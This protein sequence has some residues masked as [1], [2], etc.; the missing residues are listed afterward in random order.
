MPVRGL[1]GRLVR[2]LAAVAATA[3]AL[4]VP[5]RR[6]T[7]VWGPVPILSNKYWSSAMREAGWPSVTLMEDV[8]AINDRADFDYLMPD[9]VPG[10]VRPR[11]LRRSL[12]RAAALLWTVRHARVVHLPFDGGPLG[13]TPLWRLEAP[14]YRRKGIRMVVMPYGGDAYPYSRVIDTSLRAALQM[15]YPAAARHEREIAER[16]AYWTRHADVMI[17][18]TMIDGIGRSDV[19][20]VQPCCIDTAAWTAR[21]EYSTHDGRTG[22]VTILHTPNHRGFKGT[23]FLLASVDELRAEGLQVEVLLLERQPNALVRQSMAR[24]DI[25]A[26]QFIASIYALSG[27]EGMASGLPIL[28]NLESEAHTRVFRRYAYLNECPALSTT[29]ETLT[30]NLRRLV[31]DPA[32]RRTLGEAGRAYVEKYHSFRAAQYMFGSIYRKIL[33]GDD[34]D[35]MRLFHPLLSAY[36]MAEPHIVHPLVENRLPPD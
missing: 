29:P 1:I 24:A 21:E 2:G 11:G 17:A 18:G 34:V 26:E 12:G 8:Y 33:D 14:L 20:N 22:P 13:R 15:S 9:L 31:T 6:Q 36:V 16:I 28:V 30:G 7:L 23:E 4:A 32:L 3:I 5:A 27:I 25:L 19:I 10:W 35:L